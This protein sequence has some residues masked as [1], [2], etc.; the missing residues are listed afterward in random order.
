MLRVAVH[1]THGLEACLDA[2]AL[3]EHLSGSE[4]LA[5][6]ERVPPAHL[7]RVD[8]DALG[9]AVEHPIDGE[10][11]LV[12]AEPAHRAGRRVVRVD[13]RRFDVD[14]VEPIGAASVS[15][16]SLEHLV[17]DAR[18]CAGVPNDPSPHGGQTPFV[19]APDRVR[20]RQRVAFGVEPDALGAAHREQD[21]T[22]GGD[23][24][25]R[26]VALHVQVLL[27][28][29]RSPVRDLRDAYALL[30]PAKERR[31]LMPVLPHALTLRRD[32]QRAVGLGNRESRLGL[33]EGVLDEL[34]SERLGQHVGR[35]LEPRVDV[36]A[37]NDRRREHVAALV[38]SRRVG[39]QRRER[40][41]DRVEH[42]V[43][44]VD[45]LGGLAC[46]VAALRH[47]DREDVADVAQ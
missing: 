10:H 8:S 19:V 3:P 33:E 42:L 34:R 35:A 47:D 15:R 38:Q 13:R 23:G 18:I 17:A 40:V 36:A 5:D 6:V 21:G 31:D 11:H 32:V 1:V 27:G 4:R 25:E 29:E 20:H 7:P 44:D 9:E 30:R 37:T 24:A 46:A 22:A 16:G 28:A 39:L 2:D 45:E 14:G 43:L 12:H 41:R 26:G